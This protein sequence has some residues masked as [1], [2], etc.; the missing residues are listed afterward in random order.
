M[1][2]DGRKVQA[3]EVGIKQAN[4]HW[5]EYELEDGNTI[6]IKLVLVKVIKVVDI[7][8]ELTGEPIYITNTQNLMT[9][10]MKEAQK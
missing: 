2:P 10:A 7:K 8:N 1:L 4:E 3:I 9:L 5:N 6:K